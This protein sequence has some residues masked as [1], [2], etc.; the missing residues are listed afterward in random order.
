[1]LTLYHGVAAICSQKVRICLAEKGLDYEARDATGMLRD[2]EYLKLN[3]GGYVP[4]LIHD[5]MALTESRIICEY[6]NDVFPQ[7]P[8]LPENPYDRARVGLWTKQIDDTLHLNIFTL[9][10]AVIFRHHYANMP[11]KQLETDLPLD[12][13]KR[14]R[15]R[16]LIAN[17]ENSRFVKIALD[18]F[19]RLIDDLERALTASTWLVGESYTLADCDYTPYMQRLTDLGL[20]F[21][22][23][24]KPRVNDWFKRLRTRPS[25]GSVLTDWLPLEEVAKAAEMAP[26]YAMLFER[27]LLGNF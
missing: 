22:W 12:P 13:T 26:T 9:S 6:L 4:T 1:M 11:P 25:F 24:N 2:P 27:Q 20:E 3:P 5:G 16:D 14:E 21:L 8:L 23:S 15:T 19:T 7:P 17:G 10:C 18:R